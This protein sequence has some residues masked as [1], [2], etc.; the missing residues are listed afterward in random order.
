MNAFLGKICHVVDFLSAPEKF[1]GW[2]KFVDQSFYFFFLDSVHGGLFKRSVGTPAVGGKPWGK[3]C[4][5]H[6]NRESKSRPKWP[7]ELQIKCND[8]CTPLL[9]EGTQTRLEEPVWCGFLLWSHPALCTFLA[10]DHQRVCSWESPGI[11]PD[12]W[13]PQRSRGTLIRN[14]QQID[15]ASAILRLEIDAAIWQ[16]FDLMNSSP[17]TFPLRIPSYPPGWKQIV[18]NMVFL[19]SSGTL[20]TDEQIPL[21]GLT[22]WCGNIIHLLD[23][24]THIFQFLTEI[25]SITESQTVPDLCWPHI[26]ITLYFVCSVICVK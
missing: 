18:L 9:L 5:P 20:G 13:C 6:R 26:I 16:A 15:S 17:V 1:C 10:F 22:P 25:K 2:L 19:W 12:S 14:P 11:F 24:M 23:V 21:L 8:A 4:C 7:C 3:R